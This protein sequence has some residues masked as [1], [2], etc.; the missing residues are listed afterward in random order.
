[1]GRRDVSESALFT[2]IFS[3]NPP[4]PGKPRLSSSQRLTPGVAG[5]DFRASPNPAPLTL[6]RV[7]TLPVPDL[8]FGSGSHAQ[9]SR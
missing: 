9:T 1:V 5:N 2:E 6:R 3:N 8:I 4:Q 7:Q